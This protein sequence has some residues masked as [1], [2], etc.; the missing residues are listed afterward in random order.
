[1]IHAQADSRA[2]TLEDCPAL[3]PVFELAAYR[4]RVFSIGGQLTLVQRCTS[5]PG[6]RDFTTG[7]AAARATTRPAPLVR[8]HPGS[9]YLVDSLAGA[10][11]TVDLSADP[12]TYA[13]AWLDSA[14]GE[15][16]L[17]AETV[18]GGKTVSLFPPT[19]AM[20]NPGAFWLSRRP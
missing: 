10:P 17:L 14:G 9:A 6:L 8:T 1:V 4:R 3:A 11:V 5:E 12:A 18:S 15:L 19:S 7:F 16:H 13:V 20:K 2:L